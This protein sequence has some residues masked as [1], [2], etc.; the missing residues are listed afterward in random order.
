[1]PYVFCLL[2]ELILDRMEHINITI[3]AWKNDDCKPH[4]ATHSSIS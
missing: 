2:P 3:G 4:S 1:M